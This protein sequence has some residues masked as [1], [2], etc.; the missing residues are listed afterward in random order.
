[1][2]LNGLELIRDDALKFVPDNFQRIREWAVRV[3][4]EINILI[5]AIDALDLGGGGD[6][7]AP[8]H[9]HVIADITDLGYATTET[10]GLVELA[11]NG[12]EADSVVVQG[13][14]QRLA[15]VIDLQRKINLLIKHFVVIGL[16]PPT[17]LEDDLEAA[18]E[19]E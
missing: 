3:V 13:S 19:T 1:M 14:D 6:A 8:P 10:P 7:E 2:T 11:E 4:N 18:L 17:G 12:E 15:T 16:P 5:A 9:T